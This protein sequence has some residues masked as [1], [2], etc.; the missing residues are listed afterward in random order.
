MS[1]MAEMTEFQQRAAAVALMK[2]LN[3]KHF[4]VSDLQ[5]I[6]KTMGRESALGG[7]DLDA[8]RGLHC[9]DYA[10]MGRE[11]ATMV[12]EKCCEMLGL[13]QTVIEMARETP[14]E[15]SEPAHEPANRLRL[16][17]WKRA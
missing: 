15:T 2:L 16:A 12:R 10:D 17:F 11:L 13:P 6:A 8:L 3:C 7:R 14:R 5:S 1:D 9:V 4:S